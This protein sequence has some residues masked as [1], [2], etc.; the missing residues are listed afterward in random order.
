ME[1]EQWKPVV[2]FEGLYEVS[3]HGRVR[4]LDKPVSG[5]NGRLSIRKGQIVKGC[6]SHGKYLQVNLYKDRKNNTQKIHRLVAIAF[7]SNP[8]NYEQ[9]NH[10]DFD[11]ENNNLDNLEWCSARQNKDYSINAGRQL[12]GTDVHSV[13]LT[14]EDI[15]E[16]RRIYAETRTKSR[17]GRGVLSGIAAKYGV[18]PSSISQIVAR[19]SWKHI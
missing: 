6:Y 4:S 1:D 5:P 3:S 11:R 7:L 10:K 14:D 17:V 2:G 19:K 18:C 13:K 9:V 12:K 16:I 15:L 8:E